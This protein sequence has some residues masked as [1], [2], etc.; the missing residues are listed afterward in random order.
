MSNNQTQK[1][2]MYVALLAFLKSNPE[3]LAKLPNVSGYIA[4]LESLVAAIQADDLLTKTRSER[5]D[6]DRKIR[7][8]KT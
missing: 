7:R 8:N 3:V 5:D 4:Q 2:R 1:L 6:P